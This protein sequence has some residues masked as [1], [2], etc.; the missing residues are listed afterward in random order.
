MNAS[1]VSEIDYI[2]ENEDIDYY[3]K[4]FQLAPGYIPLADKKF[5]MN[6]MI[7]GDRVFF[8][9]LTSISK[10]IFVVIIFSRYANDIYISQYLDDELGYD[11]CDIDYMMKNEDNINQIFLNRFAN[12]PDQ[13]VD[14]NARVSAL[15]HIKK[16]F[17]KNHLPIEIDN[18]MEPFKKMTTEE[19]VTFYQKNYL[20]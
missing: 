9:G 10:S 4:S 2:D 3:V 13:I 5:I 15:S 20:K 11:R 7:H 18:L 19:V 8:K 16:E 1:E 6:S 14:N 12:V 17:L